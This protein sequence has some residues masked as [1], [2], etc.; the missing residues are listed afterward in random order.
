MQEVSQR[1]IKSALVASP[2]VK[3]FSFS[4]DQVCLPFLG[5]HGRRRRSGQFYLNPGQH[6]HLLAPCH[7]SSRAE[8]GE[9]YIQQFKVDSLNVILFSGRYPRRREGG[10]WPRRGHRRH[11]EPPQPCE[12]GAGG[13]GKLLLPP[14]GQAKGRARRHQ[15]SFRSG[16]V[17]CLR[18]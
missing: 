1:Q 17:L 8:P 16:S 10:H 9:N 7:R 15:G 2:S 11:R 6:D 13:H 12:G 4:G 5:R 3:R 14:A 18:R